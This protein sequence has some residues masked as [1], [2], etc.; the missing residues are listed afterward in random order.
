MKKI[1]ITLWI[2]LMTYLIS[3]MGYEYYRY[4]QYMQ[5]KPLAIKL[6]VETSVATI[7]IEADNSVEWE[8]IAKMLTLVLVTYG[9]IKLINKKLK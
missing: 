4:Y 8:L 2:A 3:D 5:H 1:I 6:G 9:G 7:N